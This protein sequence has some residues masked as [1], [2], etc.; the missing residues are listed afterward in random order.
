MMRFMFADLHSA[1]PLERKRSCPLPCHS[2]AIG[3]LLAAMLLATPA[4]L[5]AAGAPSPRERLSFNADWRFIKGDPAQSEG[6]LTYES[7]KPWLLATGAELS[8]N[9]TP[10]SRPGGNPGSDVAYT[11]PTFDDAV[12][13]K[14]VV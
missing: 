2:A 7:L 13:R 8:L 14:S 9:A 5:R 4:S 11:Q 12:D 1:N 6:K 3:L 10:P